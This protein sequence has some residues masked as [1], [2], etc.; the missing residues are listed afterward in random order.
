LTPEGGG[1]GF[2]EIRSVMMSRRRPRVLAIYN[3]KG[4]VGKITPIR[5][6]VREA[7]I[8]LLTMRVRVSI[9]SLMLSVVATAVAASAA[10]V[11]VK[12]PAA[13]VP[14]VIRADFDRQFT[15]RG[16]ELVGK[17][18]SPCFHDW[19]FRGLSGWMK[20]VFPVTEADRA[21]GITQ[22]VVYG[23]GARLAKSTPSGAFSEAKKE[24]TQNSDYPYL[25]AYV[26]RN[27]R[28]DKIVDVHLCF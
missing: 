11:N 2:R 16:P 13:A 3:S 5:G 17:A 27:G 28:L 4:G 12:I 20:H 24:F 9:V 23:F 15:L 8:G 18:A 10:S 7:Q 26:V 21:N 14:V 6:D 25:G 22:H 1:A 19:R